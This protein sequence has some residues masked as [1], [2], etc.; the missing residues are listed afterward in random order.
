M[1][2]RFM[3]SFFAAAI[4]FT[5]LS[6]FTVT[7]QDPEQ[8]EIITSDVEHFWQAFDDAAKVPAEQQAEVYAREYF[9]PGSQGFKDFI[10]FRKVTPASFAAHVEQ[11]RDYYATIR[12]RIG[13]VVGQK[14]MIQ[15][16]FR[17][18][19]ALYPDISFP[20]HAYFVV[21]TQHGAGMNSD[22][23]IILAA[24]MFATPPGTPY[25]YNKVYPEYVP[26]S[27]VH[28]TVHF[29]QS[30][31]IGDGAPLLP[32]VV[33]E[34]SADFIASLV[35][36]EP[37][38]RQTTDRWQYGCARESALAARFMQELDAAQVQPWLYDHAPDTGWP[39]DMGYWLG[40][41][42]AQTYYAQAKDKTAALRAILQVTDFKALL[43]ASG[44]PAAAPACLPAKPV[45]E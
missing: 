27:V 14:P 37:A 36:P 12:P 18:F 35:L 45:Q 17:R 33:N 8:A 11:N 4:A 7:T 29:N 24:E 9:D 38:V 22:D 3:R 19:K 43:K 15:A 32:S 16:A 44:Y 2:H 40:Y 39:P 34:G 10:A 41:R 1:N 30:F 23:G 28:E 6:G 25:G 20:K 31:Q 13:E 26:F 21:G 5:T 42:I